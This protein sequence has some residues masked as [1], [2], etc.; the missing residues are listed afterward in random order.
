MRE[1]YIRRGDGFALVYSVCDRPSFE[2]V[3]RTVELI[4]RAKDRDDWPLVILANKVDLSTVSTREI[5]RQE[6]E[7]MAKVI[8]APH[9]EVSAKFRLNV[10][11]AFHELVRLMRR[12]R[13][14]EC[15]PLTD[16]E[17]TTSAKH[18]DKNRPR[19]FCFC[20]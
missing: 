16:E 8:G 5:S 2:T 18:V 3:S 15:P 17:A 9:F 13:A 4:R 14:T 7:A 20:L 19:R 10:D 11:Q 6:G 12:F 1:Q